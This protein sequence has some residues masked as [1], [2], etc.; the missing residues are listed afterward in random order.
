[1]GVL[2]LRIPP[3]PCKPF[4]PTVGGSHSRAAIKPQLFSTCGAALM[5]LATCQNLILHP[6][7]IGGDFGAGAPFL[8]LMPVHQ[9]RLPILEMKPVPRPRWIRCNAVFCSSFAAL[10]M[11]PSSDCA[12]TPESGYSGQLNRPLLRGI[13]Y[14]HWPLPAGGRVESEKPRCQWSR[15][16]CS[17]C[18]FVHAYNC[19][20]W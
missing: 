20:T 1:M 6:L 18:Y 3:S 13:G 4:T 17:N 16:R 5:P 9:P 10:V 15:F 7:R 19:P 11:R 12:N 2:K 8:L 14:E